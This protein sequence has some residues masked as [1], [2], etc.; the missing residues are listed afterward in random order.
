VTFSLPDHWVWDFWIADDGDSFHLYYLHAPISLGDPELRHRNAAIGHASSPDLVD[1]TD[2]GRVIGPGQAGEADETASWTGSVI[3]DDAGVW[4]MFYTGSRFLAPETSVN[5]ESIVSASSDDLQQWRTTPG[6]VLEADPRWYETLADGTWHE[7][8]WR[9]PW[10]V[11]DALGRWHMLI[12]ARAGAGPDDRDRGVVGHAVSDDLVHWDVRPPLSDPGAG[13]AHLEVVQWVVID[14]R[15]TILFSCDTSHLA[16]AR[17]RSGETGGVW[18]V[19][20]GD[21]GSPIDA[22]AATRVI[23]ESLYAGRAVRSRTGEWVLLGFENM[24]EGGEFIG[25]LSDPIRLRWDEDGALRADAR[26][27]TR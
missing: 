3:R 18:A 24:S 20:T 10:V 1:W 7:L 23:D 6:A 14:G 9:D 8:A 13:F 2:H 15:P 11:Q 12:T 17:A 25:R 22:V 26:E 16:G 27:V 21:V 19:P 5:V 4:R